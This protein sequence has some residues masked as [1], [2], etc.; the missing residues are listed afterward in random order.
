MTDELKEQIETHTKLFKALMAHIPDLEPVLRYLYAHYPNAWTLLVQDFNHVARQTRANESNEFKHQ[1]AYLLPNPGCDVLL[2]PL[3]IG[4]SKEDRGHAHGWTSR[5]L[6]PYIDRLC[7]EPWDFRPGSNRPPP[8]ERSDRQKAR[9][10][11]IMRRIDKKTYAP[12][13]KLFPSFLY[14]DAL[15]D[16]DDPTSGLCRSYP[17][18]RSLRHTWTSPHTAIEGIGSRG[19][20]KRC[21]ARTH[22]T[23][24][25][26]SPMVAYAVSQVYLM[27]HPCDWD[28]LPR[29]EELYNEILDLFDGDDGDEEW[30]GDTLV[31]LQGQVFGCDRST[32]VPQGPGSDESEPESDEDQDTAATIKT[33]ARRRRAQREAAAAAARHRR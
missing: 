32:A 26:K 15:Y 13:V 5:L 16:K 19:I 4:D 6:M 10:E 18:I 2:P 17:I 1:F 14:D 27:L 28:D 22:K 30:A 24:H 21:N 31:F 20:P 29:V 12:N 7:L 23:F 25:M 8:D 9:G 11:R 3:S 33:I